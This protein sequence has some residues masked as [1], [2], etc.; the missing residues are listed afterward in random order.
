MRDGV[1]VVF[2]ASGPVGTD[3]VRRL[4]TSGRTVRAVHRRGDMRAPASVEVAAGDLGRVEDAVRLSQNAAVIYCCVGVKDYLGWLEFWPP[5]VASLLAAAEASGA[6]IVFC[7]N[8]YAYGPVDGPL[9]EGL[10]D[11]TYGKK[12]AL[13]ARLARQLLQAHADGRARVAIARGSDFY[14]PGVLAAFLGERVFPRALANKPAELVFNIDY[15][16][17]YTY[18]PDFARAMQTLGD[19]DDAFG[20]IWHVPNAPTKT[21]REIV[22]RIYE[23]VGNEPKIRVLPA[24]MVRMLGLFVPVMREIAEMRFEWER[25]YVVDHSRFAER[26][27]DDP[28]LFDDGLATTIEWYREHG[29]QA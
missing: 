1:D 15:P 8:L 16:H 29:P 9:H 18:V 22:N 4:A 26:Y 6:P 19:N 27:W 11:T 25:P 2:G 23:L 24:W 7:D 13:R 14:G 20:Q 12:P 5:V 3:L 21:T 10:P 28:T 17:S